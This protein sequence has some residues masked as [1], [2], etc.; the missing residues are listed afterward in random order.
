MAHWLFKSEPEVW[1]WDDQVKKGTEKWDGIRNHTAKQNMMAMKRGDRAF[2]YHSGEAREIVGIVEVVREA[3][4]DPGDP[5]GTFVMVD[6]KAVKPV[7]T[8]VTLS[9][10]KADPRLKDMKLVR[11]G[12]LSVSP[13]TDAEWKI[14]CKAGG[15]EP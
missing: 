13:V 15:V 5:T 6:I 3:Y 7:K 9:A 14:L 10:I 1:S 11:Q 2:F 4:P 8:P 12:R